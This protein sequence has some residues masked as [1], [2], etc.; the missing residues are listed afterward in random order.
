MKLAEVRQNQ[1]LMREAN[2]ELGRQNLFAFCQLMHPS[3]F[4]ADRKYLIDTCAKIQHFVE[5][6]DKHFLIVNEPPRHGKSLTAQ[7]LTAWLFGKDSS[8]RVMTASYNE[9]LSGLF[10]RTV[11]NLIQTEKVDDNIVYSDLF[12]AR[13]KYGEASA[14]M[15]SLEGQS[16]VSYLATS[17]SATATG[18]G[19]DFLICDDLIKKA[20]DAY[21]ENSLED[22]WLWFANTMLSRLEGP[23]KVI[24]IMTRWAEGD[25][26][27]RVMAAYGDDVEVITYK[28]L[29]D[30]GS[31]LCEEI[32]NREDYELI[33]REM[34]LDIVEANYNQKPIDVGGRLYAGFKEWDKRP[35]GIIRNYTDTADTGTDFLCSINYIEFEKEAY[36]TDLVFTDQP[37]EITEPLVADLLSDGGVNEAEIESNNG[38]RGF[39]RN[40]EAL[41]KSRSNKTYIKATPQTKNK[42]S[43]I[44]ASSA[45]VQNHVYMPPNWRTRW[46]E[47]YKQTMS[48]QRKGKNAHDDGPD[49]L[50]AIY[51][52]ITDDKSIQFWD[53]D[54]GARRRNRNN[55]WI[56][57]E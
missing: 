50:A 45:W 55:Y 29:Q 57:E 14:S 18:M 30:D 22:T 51:E 23:R 41:L 42:E 13:V 26:A 54:T 21:N 31:M 1:A 20:E 12:D 48:Y 16:Q 47:F 27:G 37:Q 7:D 52:Q 43:R 34:N 56:K 33:I 11:R 32:L 6:S 3:L 2:L 38:G 36:I 10:A 53:D 49:V 44:L 39:A 35:D 19:C 9:R 17:P 40:V 46:P 15:W 8:R 5:A 25:L 4:T 24:I 28:A